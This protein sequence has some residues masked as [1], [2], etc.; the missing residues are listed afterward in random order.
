MPHMPFLNKTKSTQ[1]T[2]VIRTQVFGDT[3][4][5]DSSTEMRQLVA[6]EYAAVAGGPELQIG[7]G[8]G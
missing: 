7:D 1:S 4:I 2:P 3:Q 6:G 5:A 8:G